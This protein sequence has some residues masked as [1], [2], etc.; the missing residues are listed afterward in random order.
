VV[1]LH[2]LYEAYGDQV[3]LLFI[4]VRDSFHPLHPEL[5]RVAEAASLVG[6]RE[7]RQLIL[8]AGI[9]HYHLSFPCLIDTEDHE[10]EN[11][12]R[13]AHPFRIV[14]VDRDG[15]TTIDTGP[16]P[17]FPLKWEKI[18][19]WM[20]EQGHSS[21]SLS[22]ARRSGLTS[23]VASMGTRRSCASQ[24]FGYT[25]FQDC[26]AAEPADSSRSGHEK[27]EWCPLTS[28]ANTEMAR[29]RKKKPHPPELPP[30]LADHGVPFC[31]PAFFS[32]A[33]RL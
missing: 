23:Q 29:R 17:Y 7:K 11:R 33:W 6:D 12:Y 1:H 25:D 22:E 28:S 13:G 18:D 5:Q 14:L 4:A 20:K 26:G 9:K 24:P 31:S 21:A 16:V 30:L 8:R 10:V 32:S 15:Q 3:Q 2:Q 19:A 27:I